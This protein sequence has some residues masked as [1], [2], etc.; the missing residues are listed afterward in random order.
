[1]KLNK[2][3]LAVA[4]VGVLFSSCEQT[5]TPEPSPEAPTNAQVVYFQTPDMTGVEINPDDNV[6]ECPVVLQRADSTEALTVKIVV[7]QNDND[8]FTV[9]SSVTFAAGV[10]TDT[11]MVGLNAMDAGVTYNLVMQLDPAVVNPYAVGAE[12]AICQLGITPIKWEAGV[13]V[14][15]GGL[16]SSTFSMPSTNWYVDYKIATLPDG[17]KRL[18]I[19][20]PYT[21]LPA[22]EEIVTDENGIDDAFIYYMDALEPNSHDF[23]LYITPDNVVNFGELLLGHDWGYGAMCAVQYKGA[24]VYTE[25]VSVTFPEGAIVFAMGADLY[26]YANFS[27]YLTKEAYLEAT[28]V[29]AIEAEVSDYEGLFTANALGLDGSE[30][31]NTITITSVETEEGQLYVIENLAGLETVYG[32]F[33][34]E[35]HLMHIPAQGVG[36]FTDET[37]GAVYDLVMYTVTNEGRTSINDLVLG[38]NGD[39]TIT[40]HE[41]STTI[42]VAI[43]AFNQADESD[44][45]IMGGSLNISLTAQETPAAVSKKVAPKAFGKKDLK[46]PFHKDYM[47]VER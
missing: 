18:R 43:V 26:N 24:G 25:G 10:A 19:I 8:A 44:S 5:Y 38:Y 21:K 11:L 45:G 2:L 41:T 46:V 22:G 4:T 33:D 16:M 14:F 34:A 3:F 27:L 42:G 7:T 32:F 23:M 47:P 36:T 29:E 13:G 12:N 37:K 6:T 39:G 20:A 28:A 35:T 40:I 17:S 1:M 31:S 15:C 9:P 30:V